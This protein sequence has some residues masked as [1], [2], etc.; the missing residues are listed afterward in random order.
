M[1]AQEAKENGFVTEV[2]GKAKVDKAMAQMITNCGYTGEIEI[3]YSINIK[4]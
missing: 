3:T 2:T 4:K 1:S